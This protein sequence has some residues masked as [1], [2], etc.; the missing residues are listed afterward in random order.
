MCG[1][2]GCHIQNICG[3]MVEYSVA[4]DVARTRFPAASSISEQYRI[5]KKQKHTRHH[6]CVSDS[7]AQAVKLCFSMLPNMIEVHYEPHRMKKPKRKLASSAGD[8][9]RH[10]RTELPRDKQN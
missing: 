4:I 5:V 3:L 2:G 1:A 6:D 10:T 8:D 7:D 9:Y